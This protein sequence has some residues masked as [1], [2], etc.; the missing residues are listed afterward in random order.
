MLPGRADQ[1]VWGLCPADEV[2]TLPFSSSPS[3]PV[4]VPMQPVFHLFSLQPVCGKLLEEVTWTVTPEDRVQVEQI[5]ISSFPTYFVMSSA[6]RKQCL[7]C[8]ACPLAK[9][10]PDGSGQLCVCRPFASMS[11]VGS[12]TRNPGQEQAWPQPHS[13]EVL[14]L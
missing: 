6:T 9:L 4:Q 8:P 5:C 1:R 12:R 3:F 2:C 7:C 14:F 10:R 11:E 13:S